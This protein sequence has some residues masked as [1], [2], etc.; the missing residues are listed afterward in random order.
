MADFGSATASVQTSFLEDD[1]VNRH[2]TRA[3]NEFAEC[4]RYSECESDP[5]ILS[6]DLQNGH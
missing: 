4:C 3:M 2:D 1:K 6:H 5:A